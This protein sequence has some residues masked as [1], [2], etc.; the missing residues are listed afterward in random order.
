MSNVGIMVSLRK[1]TTGL[2]LRLYLSD[3][4]KYPLFFLELPYDLGFSLKLRIPFQYDH[5][6]V[7]PYDISHK[8]FLNCFAYYL[9]LLH[10]HDAYENRRAVLR[11]V[12][13]T[14]LTFIVNRLFVFISAFSVIRSIFFCYWYLSLFA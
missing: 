11:A 4:G 6:R 13:T 9:Y 8:E 7:V 10:S 5:E 3:Y 14:S 2:P 12:D 1:V